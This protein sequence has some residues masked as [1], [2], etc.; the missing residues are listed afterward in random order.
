MNLTVDGDV[1]RFVTTMRDDDVLR[2]EVSNLRDERTGIH[3]RLRVIL[4]T[5]VL[6]WSTFNLERDE[7]RTRLSNSAFKNIDG[8]LHTPPPSDRPFAGSD[9]KHLIDI[10]CGLC[11]ATLVE[12]YGATELAG[13]AMIPLEH[14]ARPHILKDGGTFLFGL[15][16]AGKSYTAMFMGVS[17][18]AGMNHFWETQQAKVM[19]IN[20]ERGG[21]SISR[22]I[23]AVNSA[24]GV[25]PDR[26]LLTINARGKNLR[27]IIETVQRDVDKHRVELVI[28][29]SVS[30]MGMGDLTE[31]RPG[32]AIGDS[33]NKVCPSWLAIAH[34][35]RGD[36]SHI[37]GSIMFEAAADVMV[38]TLSSRVGQELGIG[39]EVTKANDMGPVEPMYLAYSFDEYGVK[40]I[41]KA[42]AKEFPEITSQHKKS[43]S[44]TVYDYL[45]AEASEDTP[46]HI[47]EVLSKDRSQV[48]H[49]LI[50]D[51]RFT[52]TRKTGREAFYAVAV[53][54][55]SYSEP[56]ERV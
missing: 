27:D 33:L 51:N 54:S 48:A 16:E 39:L 46:T 42:S 22:R 21:K 44:D 30:R 7:D 12:S 43:L 49:I 56:P 47:S 8:D 20:L 29:D 34:S 35:P 31:N 5:I 50:K 6:A 52:K 55:F 17:I 14:W 9:M 18:D 36:N 32:T 11:W 53:P 19:Y 38:R 13:D 1:V 10:F 15:P 23:G 41:R 2:F 3:G 28:L 37:F 4:N 26:P 45:L 24:L 40:T 25:D